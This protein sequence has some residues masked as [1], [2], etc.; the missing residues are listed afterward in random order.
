MSRTNFCT[1]FEIVI[2]DLTFKQNN[3]QEM[4][5]DVGPLSTLVKSLAGD[6]EERREAVGLLLELCDLVNVR[7][8][9]GRVQGCIVMLVAILKGNDQ[10]ASYDARKLLNVLSGNTQNVLYMAEAGYYKP[11]VQFLKEGKVRVHKQ[12]F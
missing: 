9:L 12:K 10:I 6:E 4:M 3:L 8:R 2:F 7:R 5:A 11:M 1:L